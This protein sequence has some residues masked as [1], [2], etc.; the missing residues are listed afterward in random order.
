MRSV[1]GKELSMQ[2][3]KAAGLQDEIQ[4]LSAKCPDRKELFDRLQGI[5]VDIN[6][7]IKLA[8]IALQQ[9]DPRFWDMA[10]KFLHLIEHNLNPIIYFYLPGLLKED[11]E[12]VFI[13]KILKEFINTSKLDFIRDIVIR[14]DSQEATLPYFTD[15]PVVFASP[16]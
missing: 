3:L 16:Q 13:R 5:F 15:V 2:K 8:E 6:S 14:L 11:N 10:K 12:D 7:H 9:S 1:L 4:K